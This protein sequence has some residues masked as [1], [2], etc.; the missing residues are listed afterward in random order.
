MTTI[1]LSKDKAKEIKAKALE[2]VL[3][4][5]IEESKERLKDK[6]RELIKAEKIAKNLQ[7][8]IEDLELELQ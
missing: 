6:Y 2:E 4:E 1:R 5:F 8:E 7:R 3:E